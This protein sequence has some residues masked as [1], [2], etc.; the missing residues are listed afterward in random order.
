MPLK[1]PETSG[2]VND[3]SNREARAPD[4][5]RAREAMLS[6]RLQDREDLEAAR[7]WQRE[8]SAAE[9]HARAHFDAL[10]L[11]RLEQREGAPAYRPIGLAETDALMD[12]LSRAASD[13]SYAP[14][15]HWHRD[16]VASLRACPTAGGQEIDVLQFVASPVVA[17]R[18]RLD[19]WK[20]QL[21]DLINY[22][23]THDR[24]RLAELPKEGEPHDA[25]DQGLEESPPPAGD[26]MQTSMDEMA[27]QQ[28]GGS[29]G[30]FTVH[31]FR[32]G[33]YRSQIFTAHRDGARWGKDASVY[34]PSPEIGAFSESRTMRGTVPGGQVIDLPIPYGFAPDPQSL[35]VA[36]GVELLYSDDGLWRIDAQA[37][38]EK[39]SFTLSIGKSS[40]AY[41]QET[42]AKV[43]VRET[44]AGPEAEGVLKNLSGNTVEKSRVIKRFVR[45]LLRYSNAS[46]LN[47]VYEQD[48][49]GYFAAIET[50]KKADCDVAN[51][52]FINLLSRVG[53][54]ARM[55]I[56]HYVKMKD[57]NDAAVLG[58]GTS[59]AWTEVW[60][61]VAKVWV[62]FDATPPGDPIMD[63]EQS[64]ERKADDP[65]PGDYDEVEAKQITEEEM[66]AFEAKIED[67]KRKMSEALTSPAERAAQEFAA[68]AGCTPE[69]ARAAR[70][71]IAEARVLADARGRNVRD[72]LADEFQKIVD[73]NQ[74]EVSA[75]RGPV[76]RSQGDVLADKR[77]AHKDVRAGTADPLGYERE[78]VEMRLAQEYGGMDVWLVCDRSESMRE[79]DPTTNHAKKDEQQLAAFLL[80]DSIQAFTYKTEEAARQDLLVS[81]LNVRSS[82]IAFQGG[83]A[84]SIK[85]L[86]LPWAE[87]AQYEVWHRLES[88]IGGGTPAHLG[89][90]KARLEI[91]KAI[92]EEKK[93][94]NPL[95]AK[96]RLR[97]VVVFM[98]GAVDDATA[99]FAEQQKL[100]ELGVYVSSWGMT[101]SA[102][103]VEAYPNGHCVSS[104]RVMI[105]PVSHYIVE[106]AQALKLENP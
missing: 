39:S 70:K 93:N 59:H 90:Q 81:P 71:K 7:R 72:A 22:T 106:R 35:R 18:A 15:D 49:R 99:Y 95:Y 41:R 88:N 67:A 36:P 94:P 80:L 98:D 100:E 14:E 55:A 33:Y 78:V 97:L 77:M 58:S 45:G 44:F 27:E 54:K 6:A 5:R 75:Y 19:L 56:G 79:I 4:L 42:A 13:P 85:S 43:A 84:D 102:R 65:G 61:E 52:Y 69:Q 57:A 104:A 92:E 91:E 32:G 24:A 31:P 51:A 64:D 50:Y 1:Q 2:V 103:A 8:G 82:V 20:K 53:I 76:T 89:L 96:K 46:A 66:R 28:E 29:K 73:S 16:L 60:D 83:N 23:E 63:E 40:A 17:A 47:S 12:A 21:A 68:K 34:G 25:V 105:E 10:A 38:S 87:R 86:G 37:V 30:Y 48:P 74:K 3:S 26:E 101:E 11:A 9:Q 62:R